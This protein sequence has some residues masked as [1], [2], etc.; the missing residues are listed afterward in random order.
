MSTTYRQPDFRPGLPEPTP[1]GDPVP[2]LAT[3]V[4]PGAWVRASGHTPD[5]EPITVQGAVWDGP[6][7]LGTA[8]ALL[9]RD[10]RARRDVAVLVPTV[11]AGETVM[12]RLR[13]LAAE[14]AG[15]AE[16]LGLVELIDDPADR[17]GHAEDALAPAFADTD[18]ERVD[19]LIWPG[20]AE[21]R[22][23]FNVYHWTPETFEHVTAA[24]LRALEAAPDVLI[25]A[26]HWEG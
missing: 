12:Q 24:D 7:D 9:V 3:S 22:D 18:A 15:N 25:T 23:R 13:R 21:G 2:V 1:A 4:F 5:G 17:E 19:V 10:Y 20:D 26:V 11:P 16:P 8:V 14:R 6:R